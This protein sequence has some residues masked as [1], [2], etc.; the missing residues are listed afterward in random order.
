MERFKPIP[1]GHEDFKTIIENGCYYVD[2]TLMIKEL[3]DQQSKVSLFTRPRRTVSCHH[4]VTQRHE[5]AE[6]SICV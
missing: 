2:K 5:T 4:A 6:L 1:I 3:I